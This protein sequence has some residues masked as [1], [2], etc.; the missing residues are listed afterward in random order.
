M[1]NYKESLDSMFH[2]LAD[3][4]RR[5]MIDRLAKEATAAGY[6]ADELGISL[7]AVL[8]HLAVLED[9]GL[10]KTEKRGR[11]RM[12]SLDTGALSAVERWINER[13]RLWEHRLDALGD[14]LTASM[15]AE[16]EKGKDEK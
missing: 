16:R 9:S 13:R 6:F 15:E 8:Q 1:P 2:A 12:C 3:S 5:A 10:V 11:K 4:N 7:P 14:Y